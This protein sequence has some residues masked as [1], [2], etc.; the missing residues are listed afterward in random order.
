MPE[1][2]EQPTDLVF[3]CRPCS[4]VGRCLNSSTEEPGS[5]EPGSEGGR[6]SL[7]AVG[8]SPTTQACRAPRGISATYRGFFPGVISL[9]IHKDGFRDRLVQII[10]LALPF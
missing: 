8:V 7:G 4:L 10:T 6:G 3:K 2:Q 1:R 9:T 5:K